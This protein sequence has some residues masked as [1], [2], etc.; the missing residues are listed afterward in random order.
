MHALDVKDLLDEAYD[1]YAR[2]E[3]VADD[4]VQVPRAFSARRTRRSWVS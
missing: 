4:P 1:R 2:P 3:F